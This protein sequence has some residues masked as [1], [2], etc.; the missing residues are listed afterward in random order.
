MENKMVF[1]K[2]M[3]NSRVGIVEPSLGVRRV[4]EKRGHVIPLPFDLVQQLLYTT[5]FGNMIKQG[6]LYIEDMEVK[7]ELGLES[8]DA[9]QPENIIALTDL[10]MKNMLENMPIDV[11]KR[12]LAKIPDVQID[13]LISFAVEKRITPLE[14]CAWLKEVTGK[15]ILSIV[16]L[17]EEVKLAEQKEKNRRVQA[18]EK[19][20][21]TN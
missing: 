17:Q 16:K 9:K 18:R 20:L 8:Y 1:I 4:W 19:G 5:G 14:K 7:K 2:N 12:E 10:Q 3:I 11:F 21:A 6:I 15:D 13:N